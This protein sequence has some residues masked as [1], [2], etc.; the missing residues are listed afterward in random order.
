MLVALSKLNS[1]F[2]I[3][4]IKELTNILKAG[5]NTKGQEGKVSIG[6]A[7]QLLA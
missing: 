7:L 1:N 4:D 2:Y 6:E 5:A 3:S